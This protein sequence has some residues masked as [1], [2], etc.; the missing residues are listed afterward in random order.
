MFKLAF[1][2]VF[3]WADLVSALICFVLM[4]MIV[5]RYLIASLNK[6]SALYASYLFYSNMAEFAQLS[7][8]LR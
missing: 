3:G 2:I 5:S 8:Y 4:S 7:A 6:F 1:A